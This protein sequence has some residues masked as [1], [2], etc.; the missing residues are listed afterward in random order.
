MSRYEYGPLTPKWYN[1]PAHLGL[2]G[3]LLGV[4]DAAS[5]V[6]SVGTLG[7]IRPRKLAGEI[8]QEDMEVL[9]V[10]G[11]D[12]LL[13]PL[14]V[15]ILGGVEL[16]LSLTEQ[17]GAVV[18]AL[19]TLGFGAVPAEGA[20]LAVDAAIDTAIGKTV[21]AVHYRKAKEMGVNLTAVDKA[22]TLAGLA[23]FIPVAPTLS[24]LQW[25]GR[26]SARKEIRKR[27]KATTK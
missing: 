14:T 4:A 11:K 3:A 13:R 24:Y 20:A 22:V 19:G 6:V 7:L 17:G 12:P 10:T 21:E 2:E 9:R 23:P 1:L 25:Y 18:A 16:A 8:L 27:Q 5:G 26:A 15:G